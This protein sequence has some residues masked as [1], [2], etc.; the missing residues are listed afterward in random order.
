[1]ILYR[2]ISKHVRL[3]YGMSSYLLCDI[4]RPVGDTSS[5]MMYSILALVDNRLGRYWSHRVTQSGSKHPT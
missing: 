2:Y 4:H 1:M 3:T 5:A